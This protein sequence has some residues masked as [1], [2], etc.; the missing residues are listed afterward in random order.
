[1][2]CAEGCARFPLGRNRCGLLMNDYDTIKGMV[3]AVNVNINGG[4]QM[5]RESETDLLDDEISAPVR[6]GILG[7]GLI[8][9]NAIMPA[10]EA[11]PNASVVAVASRDLARAQTFA[12][13]FAI[14]HVYDDYATVLENPDVEAVYIALPN[15]LHAQWAIRA[16]RAGKHILCEKPMAMNTAEAE[17]MV[18]AAE[19]ADV[20]LMEAVM[21][22]F[23]PRMRE[24]AAQV[25]AG[26]IGTPMLL[27]ASFCFTM[28]D[29]ANYRNDPAF[30][31][32]ALLD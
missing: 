23:H 6:W 17:A 8:A 25:Q 5:Q 11:V 7:P 12:A 2:I 16:A 13:D 26:A 32:G 1:M 20:L 14:P 21:Y 28:A 18:A 3:A 22:R 15:S 10:F 31:G 19:D 29:A 30:G 27:R 24:A 4:R 9:R